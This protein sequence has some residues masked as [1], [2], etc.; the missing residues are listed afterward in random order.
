MRRDLIVIGASAGGVEALQT[1][2][3]ELPADLPATV[4]VVLHVPPYGGSVLPAILSRSGPL[5]A[6]HPTT[7]DP[8]TPGE[9][10]VAPPDYHLVVDG[11][12]VLLTRG[13]R[14]NGHRPAVDV[15]FRSAAR[16]GGRR[17][18]GV[19][20][21]GVLDDGTA[22]LAAIASRGGASIVQDPDDALYPGMPANAIA[23]VPV[24]HVLP[25]VEIAKQLARLCTEE[26]DD[27]EVPAPTL[28][29]IET[30]L[31][32]MDDDAMNDPD[33]PGRPSGFSCPDCN[34]VLFEI[35]DG[36]IVRYRCR[37]GHAWSSESLLGEQ[38]QQL[39]GALWM[40]L[41]GLEEKAALSRAMGARARERN[42][43]LS[44]ARF[45][46]QANE[47]M[48]AA[49]LIRQMLE[50]HLGS[51]TGIATDVSNELNTGT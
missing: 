4:L 40:A 34:G 51:G 45:S 41:R 50:S 37:V 27:A 24:D 15:L 29:Q 19:V 31:A 48:H 3:S 2:V 8:V 5:P 7:G 32:M 47:A 10:L 46:D 26:I 20:L 22:G 11:D 36:A 49:S 23:N 6:R 30:E 39:E 33:R 35:R 21:S 25:A 16:W 1:L 17:T 38:N 12:H 42:S 44:A 9:V 18:V 14:E 43:P 28:M 13:P